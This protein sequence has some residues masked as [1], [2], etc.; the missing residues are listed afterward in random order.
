M[1][2]GVLWVSDVVRVIDGVG[3]GGDGV[4]SMQGGT[5]SAQRS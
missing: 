1:V 5:G 3:C 2:G 4:G